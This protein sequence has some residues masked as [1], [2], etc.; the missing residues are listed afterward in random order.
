[1]KKIIR[2]FGLIVCFQLFCCVNVVQAQ[3]QFEQSFYYDE[4]TKLT[5]DDVNGIDFQPFSDDLRQG[6][7]KGSTWIKV[8]IS[9]SKDFDRISR[10]YNVFPLVVGLGNFNLDHIEMYEAVN[11]LWTKQVVDHI[12]LQRP[13]ICNDDLHCFNLKTHLINPEFETVYL[14]IDTQSFRTLHVEVRPQNLLASSSIVRVFRISTTLAFGFCLFLLAFIFYAIER[15]QFLLAFAL[16][17]LSIISYLYVSSGINYNLFDIHFHIFTFALPLTLFNLRLILFIW[18]CYL[19]IVDYSPSRQYVLLCKGCLFLAIVALLLPVADL[20]SQSLELNLCTQALVVIL[21]IYAVFHCKKIP[22][23][24]KYILLT[25]YGVYLFLF[26]FGLMYSVGWFEFVL[27]QYIGFRN[28]YDFRLN[29]MPI[30]IVVFS[31]VVIQILTSKKNAYQA[32]ADAKINEAKVFYLNEKLAERED[33][34]EVLSHEVKNPLSTIRFAS[35]SIQ[36]N[37]T[38]GSDLHARATVINRSASRIDDLINQVYLSNQLDKKI[39]QDEVSDINLSDF[40]IELV[41]EFNAMHRFNLEIPIDLSIKSNE[42][43]L[44]TIFTNLIGNSIKYASPNSIIDVSVFLKDQIIGDSSM[45]PRSGGGLI[46]QNIVFL[47]SNE[48]ESLSL[49]DPEK[50]FQRYYRHD[51]FLTKPGMGIGLNIVKSATDL[52]NGTISYSVSNSIVSFNVEIPKS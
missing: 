50:V 33:M 16:F 5:I 3:V 15:S 2:A 34:A 27:H 4:T 26:F 24:I 49:P 48:V 14:K 18:L 42:F 11:G 19:A 46:D 28:Y 8:V 17:E 29:G 22:F 25:G 10:E 7:F 1:L 31:I 13:R 36:N 37:A 39:F 6:I 38:V 52:L 12:N 47:I 35:N 20:R 43:L 21:N 9:K 51:N 30:G 44:N 40:F 41:G 23:N 45:S 32:L